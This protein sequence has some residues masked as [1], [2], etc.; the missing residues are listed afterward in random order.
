MKCVCVIPARMGSSRFPGKPLKPLLGMTLIEHIYHRCHLVERFDRVVVATCDQEIFDVITNIGGE[1]VMT[2]DCHERCTDRVEEAIANMDLGFDDDDLV[3]M[4][5]GDEVMVSPEMLTG[6]I[7][8]YAAQ[9]APVTNLVSRLYCEEDHDDPNAM[10]VVFGPDH[11][12]L[13]FS[14]APIPSRFRHDA[15]PMYQQTGVIAFRAGFLREFSALEQTPLEIVES[16]DMLRVIEHNLPIIAVPTDTETVGV[17]TQND[18]IRAE[19]FLAEDPTTGRY[20]KSSR[21]GCR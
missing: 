18:L 17:D 2:S 7:E 10:K 1:A 5:Q 15:P 12:V 20:M 3:L 8:A 6:M 13:F 14:R 16:C 4:V 21:G 9:R 19:A 11:R